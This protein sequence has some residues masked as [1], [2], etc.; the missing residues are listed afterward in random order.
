[1]WGDIMVSCLIFR[2]FLL[3]FFALFVCA[4]C[5]SKSAECFQEK[6]EAEKYV[7]LQMRDLPV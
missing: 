7:L 3:G 1:M 4:A 2:V 5:S 6:T